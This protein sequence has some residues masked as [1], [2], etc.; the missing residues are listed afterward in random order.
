[1]RHDRRSARGRER[2]RRRRDRG[3]RYDAAV[4]GHAAGFAAARV[5]EGSAG[6]RAGESRLAL[7]GGSGLIAY[8]RDRGEAGRE[9]TLLALHLDLG[10]Q[11]ART[12]FASGRMKVRVPTVLP[13]STLSAGSRSPTP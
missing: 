10:L 2:R 8:A 5:G 6:L 1:R 12:G 7:A 9:R 3:R 11:R 13:A 4:A